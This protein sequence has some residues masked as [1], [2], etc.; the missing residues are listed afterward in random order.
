MCSTQHSA[1]WHSFDRVATETCNGARGQYW[2]GDMVSSIIAPDSTRSAG[3]HLSGDSWAAGLGR[4]MPYAC[5]SCSRGTRSAI[6]A[7]GARTSVR[8]SIGITPAGHSEHGERALCHCLHLAATFVPLFPLGFPTFHA[9]TEVSC[10]PDHLWQ[11]LASC[12]DQEALTT[13]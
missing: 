1:V 12:D 10:R 11:G 8:R 9:A 3:L 6:T 4:W 2:L 7:T 13:L 5:S